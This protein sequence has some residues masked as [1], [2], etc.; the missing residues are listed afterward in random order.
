[1]YELGQV[2]G[3][4]ITV[5]PSALLGTLLLWALLGAIA[6]WLG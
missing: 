5:K 1:M 3:L 4:R 2:A 6:R